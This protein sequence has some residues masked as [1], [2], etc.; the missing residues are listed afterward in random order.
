MRKIHTSAQLGRSIE[1]NE[2]KKPKYTGKLKN[3]DIGKLKPPQLKAKVG[4]AVIS[5]RTS[6]AVTTVQ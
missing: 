4:I 3:L 6:C 2:A 5:L 1:N